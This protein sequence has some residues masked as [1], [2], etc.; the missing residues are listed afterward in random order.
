MTKFILDSGDPEEYKEIADLAREKGSEIWGGTTNPSLI[1]KKLSGE[2]I[3]QEEA[4]AKQKDIVFQLLDIVPGA[5]SAEVYADST[6]TSDQMI[7][8]GR[9]I[10][11]WHERV[12]VK[13]PTTLEGFK[14]RS[15]L[16]LD[17]IPTNNTLV[18]SQ[19]Q[20][21][22]ICLHEE[23]IQRQNPTNNLYPPFISPFVGRL[24]DQD[25]NGM[26]L[27]ASGMDLKNMFNAE[28]WMLEASVR[29]TEDFK[30]GIQLHSEL[31][32]AP[33]KTYREWFELTEEERKK[34]HSDEHEESLLSIPVW[35]PPLQLLTIETLEEFQKLIESGTLNINHP[36][37][38]KG[39]ARFTEDWA[40]ILK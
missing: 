19:E 31:I 37:T 21:F 40:A 8:Q 11:K 23:I 2:K 17:K 4:F 32:T 15:A 14:A 36:L 29:V 7:E 9:E 39:I 27:I 12:V 18:F 35:N 26:D 38:E 28:L 10:G 13:L 6:T 20:I 3:T 1:A 22:A 24:D 25:F 34:I 5:V 16:R 33:A 30:K